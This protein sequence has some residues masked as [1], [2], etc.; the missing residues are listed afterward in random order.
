MHNYKIFGFVSV[1]CLASL[2]YG[3]P[4][5]AGEEAL[6]SNIRQLT[7][8][9]QRAGEGYFSADGSRMIFQSERD[10]QNPF[11]QIYLMD[12]ETGDVQRVSPGIGKTTCAWVHPSN[13]TVLYAST[14]EDPEAAQKMQAEL[15]FRASGQQ[16]RYSWDYDPNFEL[17]AQDLNSGQRTNLTSALGYD[18]EGAYSPDGRQIVFASNRLAYSETLSPEDAERFEHD[19]SFLMDLYLMNADGTDL[20]RLTH[21]RGYDGG[22]F[23]SADGKQI[24]WRRFSLDGATAEI[25]TMDLASGVERQITRT[26]V[27]SW[28]PFFHPS[29]DYLIYA[30][31]KEG[32]ANFELFM[33]DAEGKGEP[34]RVT[35]TDGF[36]GLPVFSPDGKRLSWTSKRGAGKGSQIFLAD[37]NHTEARRKLSLDTDRMAEA[38]GAKP[39]DISSTAAQIRT[40]DVRLHVERLAS[41]EMEG[42]LTGTPGER[43]ATDYVAG[44]FSQLGLAPGGE[45]GS[46][47]QAFP[48]TAGVELGQGNRLMIDG[49]EAIETVELEKDWR[50]L[51]LSRNGT[52]NPAE[53]VFAGY[54]I[55]APGVDK[56]PDY[57]AYGDLDVTDK[58]VMLLRFQPESVSPEW[59]RH[60]VHYSDLPYKA[61]V[62][63][64]LGALGIIV[65]TGP[66]A[67]AKD[68]L[69]K[70]NMGGASSATSIGGVSVSDDLAQRLLDKAGQDLKQLQTELDK[71]APSKGFQLPDI[72]IAAQ[73][74]L[75]RQKSQGRNVVG[76]LKS[77]QSSGKPPVML[78]AHVDHLG[79]GEG[80]GSLAK[81]AERGEVHYGADDNA[82]GVAAMLESAQ[83]LASLQEQGKLDA[84]RDVWFLAWSGEELGTL[85]SSHFVEQLAGKGDLQDKISAYLNMDMV[86]HLRDKVYL[87]GAGSSSVWSREIE[88]R[89]V[90]VG[91][92]VA[93]QSDPY[94]PTDTTP[95]YMKNVPTLNA[96]T[97]AHE[98]YSSPRDLPDQLNYEGIRDIARLM[99][100]ITRSLARAEEEPDYLEVERQQSGLSRKHLRAY[101]GTIPAY[102]QDESI[103]GV[104]LQG[105]VKGGPAEK[106]GVQEGDILVGL[107][108]VEVETIHDFMGALAGLKVGEKT[109]LTVLRD[110]KRVQLKVV[111]GSRE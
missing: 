80:S 54:G 64:R 38:A 87:Q 78:G 11:Y 93:T 92:P 31:N 44:V 16:R 77:D 104:K 10:R 45:D 55:V 75:T 65:V 103:K 95:F 18:A 108:G 1:I 73:V 86:G 69:V 99:A 42:R 107:A 61:S 6:L 105:A 4:G 52:V 22:P 58:W 35:H 48:F 17:Y 37:W 46:Y 19:K 53:I 51:A 96:F 89:N 109:D 59:R 63:K 110:G 94:L 91:L 39:A 27:M 34:V 43:K 20:Q 97:G 56:V 12:L 83:Y 88:R 32:F 36:D 82:S 7:F 25:F 68:R 14:H 111:P 28:A 47:F 8:E 70:L 62:A 81:D 9:G 106:A 90:P 66:N 67:Q 26:G 33:V 5:L 57:D 79:R 60:L 21:A 15:D 71:G 74:D 41:P 85:G 30:S 13:E 101:L 24:T 40:E 2:T 72:K 50:P 100:G 102:G 23:F 76:I 49:L 84:K 98:D 3:P 29:G